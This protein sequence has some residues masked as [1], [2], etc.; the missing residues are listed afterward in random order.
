MKAGADSHPAGDRRAVASGGIQ[1]VLD[2]A[3]AASKSSRQ[4][5]SE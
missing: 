5:E 3:F 1:V 4:K 2:L